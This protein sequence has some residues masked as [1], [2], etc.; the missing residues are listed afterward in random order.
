MDKFERFGD[1]PVPVNKQQLVPTSGNYP[2]GFEIGSIHVGIKPASKSQPDLVSIRST[3]PLH[4]ASAAAVFT[5]NEFPAASI[6]VSKDLLHS[7]KGHGVRGVIAN[8][9]CANTLTGVPGLQDSAAMAK[10]AGRCLADGHTDG[11]DAASFLVMHTG[12]GGQ[13]LPI[14]PI[15]QNIPNL[16]QNMGSSHQ[17]WLEGAWAL[18]TTDTFPK[19]LSTTFTLPSFGKSTKF[20]LVGIT[21]GAGMVFPNMHTTLGIFCTDAPVSPR[22]LQRLLSIAADKSYNCISIDGD[23]STNDMVALLANGAAVYSSEQREGAPAGSNEVVQV[24]WDPS[25]SEASQSHDFSVL[26]VVL[27]DFLAR[28]AQ[29]VVRDAEGATKF[30][31]IRVRGCTETEASKRIASVIARS[32]LVKT[33]IYGG[34]PNW[35]G[36]LAALGYSLVDTQFSGKGIIVPESTSISFAHSGTPGGYIK[37]LHQGRPVE[38]EESNIREIMAMEDVEVVVDLRDTGSDYQTSDGESIFWT[39][40]LTHD[41]VTINSGVEL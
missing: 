15:L 30:I 16:A 2:Q 32:S 31:T 11:E 5:K 28:A 7:S 24:D 1:R 14:E 20:S 40:D 17:H 41:F 29:L 12:I 8:S 39:S 9:W 21:K 18:A 26:Q 10:A 3:G 13:R 35:G 27:S 37:F 22:A 36:I 4:L 33:G 6:T 19:L 25:K 34:D 38:V 23:T